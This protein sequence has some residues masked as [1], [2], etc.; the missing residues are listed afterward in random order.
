MV[1]ALI[2]MMSW[3]MF[4]FQRCC[5]CGCAH[6]YWSCHGGCSYFN[7]VIMVEAHFTGVVMVDALIL[8]VLSRWM[9]SFCYARTRQAQ[10]CNLASS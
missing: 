10:R 5:H 8:L 2:L 4:L 6:F 3:W 7:G 1:D 9:R